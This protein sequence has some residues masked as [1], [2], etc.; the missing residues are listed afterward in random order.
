MGDDLRS[1]AVGGVK[2]N[3]LTS[4]SRQAIGVASRLALAWLLAPNDWGLVAAAMVV[5]TVVRSCGNFGVNYA[6]IHWR[7]DVRRAAPSALTLLSCVSLL[8]YGAVL[9]V[10]PFT[11]AYFKAPAVP[12]LT[13]LLALSL[14]LK[15]PSVVAEG[16]LR[17]EFHLRRIFFIEFPSHLTST[18][19]AIAAA[20]LLPREQRYWALVI[21]GLGREVLRTLLSW[22]LTNVPLRVGFDREAAAGLLRYGKFFVASSVLMVL[23][24]SA[25]QLV[26]GRVDSTMALGLYSFAL[27]WVSQLGNVTPTIFGGVAL[28]LYAKLQDDPERLRAAYCRVLGYAAIVSMA[29]L[30]GMVLVVPEAVRLALPE[31]YHLATQAFQILGLYWIVRAIGNTSGQLFAAIG[32]PKYDMYLNAVNLAVMVPI[33]VPLV[34]HCGPAGAALA[35]LF[36]RVV[37]LALNAVFCRRVLGLPVVRLLDSVMPATKAAAGMAGALWAAQ[38]L[39]ARCGGILGWLRLGALVAFGA[40]VYVGILYVAHRKL[41]L[42]IGGLTLEAVGLRRAKSNGS[43]S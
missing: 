25:D 29:L 38:A 40:L 34:I 4:Y 16:T 33:M 15:P 39:V 14:L 27:V 28:P 37:R 32:K 22:A 42:E 26:L 23:Y 11:S 19:A 30:S 10:A 24:L 18:V 41:F 21:G 17:R 2:W 36:A 7:G 31:G 20:L 9:L 12:L 13:K 8:A 3:V 5:I 35:V 43:A 6:L 1:R